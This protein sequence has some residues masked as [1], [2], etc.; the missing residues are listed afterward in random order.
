MNRAALIGSRRFAGFFWAQLLG[1]C[2]DNVF[3]NALVVMVAARSLDAW[4]LPPGQLVAL[5][6]AVFTLPFVVASPL[7]GQLADR[8]PK[9]TL[10]RWSKAMEVAVMLLAVPALV[11]LDVGA[12]LGVLF[13]MGLQS[14]L[15]G[16]LKHGLLP[17]LVDPAD[18]VQANALVGTSTF[19][20]ILGG[21]LLGGMLAGSETLGTGW[22]GAVVVAIAVLGWVAG[23]FVPAT[24]AAAPGLRL[25]LNPLPELVQSYGIA[26]RTRSVLLSLL[27][28]GWFWF[29]GSA[30]LSVLPVYVTDVLHGDASV[31][32]LC[33]AA[34]C[35]GIAIG[36]LA[37]AWLSGEIVELGLVPI[38]SIGISLFALD[39]AFAAVPL[40]PAGATV[41]VRTLLATGAGWR[42]ALDLVGLAAAAGL[43]VVPLL[44]LVQHRTEIATRARVIAAGNVLGAAFMVASALVVMALFAAGASVP[45]IF[46]LLALLNVV[47]AY[48]V[49]TLVPEFL[50]RFVAWM[51]A[52]VTYRMR[53][54]GREHLPAEGPAVLV[55][56]HVSF[57]D[58][59]TVASACPRPVRFVMHHGFLRLR[60]V[61]W[62]FRDA[63]VIPIASARESTA[64]LRAAYDRIAEE[65]EAGALVCIFPEGAITRDGRMA[66]FRPGIEKI[67]RRTPVPVVP[68]ALKGLWGSFFSR[69][70]GRAM[71]RP[72]RR[73]WSRIEVVVG[74]AIPPERVRAGTLRARV[75]ALGDL[76]VDEDSVAGATT[77]A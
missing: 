67:V 50:L 3:R 12:L 31:I 49:Y 54:V 73:V 43:F 17:E 71:S 26:R 33:L 25:R 56:N 40:A 44:A 77:I 13:L 38:G 55:A 18:L 30:L 6:G 47:V 36:S 68:M 24:P 70:G 10:V 41:G 60:L 4:G 19:V 20:S 7:A 37:C 72:F 46:L 61:G 5:A 48:Y 35:A 27:G 75:A 58:W 57:V 16:P 29:L 64:T 32:T 52:R 45:Q 69:R 9:S 23:T 59:L 66:E 65:L 62:L 15:F 14:T 1:A 53:V 51:L 74:E 11:A 39:L 2:N 76:D 28:I 8:W 34:F 21:T 22:I 42:I 63:K